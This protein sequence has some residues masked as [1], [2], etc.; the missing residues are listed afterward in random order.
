[1]PKCDF[2]IIALQLYGNR[3]SAWVFS[4]KLAAYFQNTFFEEH[5]WKTVS[6]FVKNALFC[7]IV[8]SWNPQ[9]FFDTISL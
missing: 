2:N 8:N 7:F 1:M 9:Y 4:C 5:P 6:D 3:T